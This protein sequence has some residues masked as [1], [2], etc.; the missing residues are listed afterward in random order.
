MEWL[1]VVL[2]CITN[3]PQTNYKPLLKGCVMEYAK[4]KGSPGRRDTPCDIK[5][6]EYYKNHKS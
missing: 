5:A 4:C 3:A 6:L 2:M 1:A